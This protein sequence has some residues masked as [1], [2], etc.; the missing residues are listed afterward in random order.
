MTTYAKGQINMLRATM[1]VAAVT[2]TGCTLNKQEAPPVSAPSEFA[3]S[4][5]VSATPDRLSQDGVSQSRV[6]AVVRNSE[7]KPAAGVALQWNVVASTGILVEPSTQQ[8]TTDAQGRAS[9]VVTAPAAPAVLPSSTT[10]L[11]ITARPVGADANST[12]NFRTAVVHLVPPPGTLPI[13]RDP[14]ASFTVAPAVG[15]IM[16]TI[17]FDAS[18][19]TDEGEPCGA[20]C[21]YQWDFGALFEHDS[22]KVVSRQFSRPGTYVITLTA[23]DSRGGVDSATR[24]VTINGPVA[25]TVTV[26]STVTG[27]KVTFNATVSPA[28]ATIEEY[29]WDFGDP[30]G[31]VVTTTVPATSHTYPAV[32]IAGTA[33]SYPVIVTV[34]DNYG[35]TAMFSGSVT[36]TTP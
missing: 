25:P 35:R 33:T 12:T 6:E 4:I 5:S 26:A 19:T 22:G 2:A 16:Q 27:L 18:G 23:I 3:Q 28:G 30:P 8:S 31:T 17:T 29:A 32:G 24:N 9:M 10:T 14:I 11:T 1:L 34:K 36:V 15:N 13:N 7:G 21:T 20:L